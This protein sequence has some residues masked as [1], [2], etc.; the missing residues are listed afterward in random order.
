VGLFLN[1]N[2]QLRIGFQPCFGG[3]T[4]VPSQNSAA[5]AL[6][7]LVPLD[8]VRGVLALSVAFFHI[9]IW[10]GQFEQPW[11]RNF[12]PVL[13]FFFVLSGFLLTLLYDQRLKDGKSA[14]DF[15]IRRI[16]RQ[17]PV[18]LFALG[19][20]FSWELS[21]AIRATLLGRTDINTFGDGWSLW[22]LIR[23]VFLVHGWGFESF[24]TW[25][26]PSWTLSTELIAYALFA[27]IAVNVKRLDMRIAA[28]VAITVISAIVFAYNTQFRYWL[29]SNVAWCL[30]GFFVGA[31]LAWAW[32]RWPVRSRALGNAIEIGC[33]TACAL[34][35]MAGPTGLSMYLLWSLCMAAL[36]Y[37]IASERGV[38]SRV[39][40]SRPLVW[41]GEI[42]L[43]IYLLHFPVMLALNQ[44]FTV[45]ERTGMLE[46]AFVPNPVR[47]GATVIR[48]GPIWL[49]NLLTLAYLA[50][51]IVV[52]AVV[53]RFI[54]APS[55]DLFAKLGTR[56]RRGEIGW[57]KAIQRSTQE[58]G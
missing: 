17:W 27:A 4:Q 39:L 45:L 6:P 11:L 31:L 14:A 16:G 8:G 26:F 48:F 24:S 2:T 12:H 20:L 56:I 51:V 50:T 18:H 29:G 44:A 35:L 41:V 5:K 7:R 25:N 38:V 40:S 30:Q 1:R 42:S 9:N 19:L 37:A 53:Y 58:S 13:G 49:M 33:L 47:P 57:P 3:S 32:Q 36:I 55:R 34:M 23:S 52:G 43:S 54:E 22:E 10:H 21:R 46:R 15:A 28:A